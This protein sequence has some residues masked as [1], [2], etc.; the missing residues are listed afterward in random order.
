[1]TAAALGFDANDEADED[2]DEDDED[3]A[4]V[5][6]KRY[7]IGRANEDKDDEV[8]V[9]SECSE[10]GNDEDDALDDLAQNVRDATLELV[11]LLDSESLLKLTVMLEALSL[12]PADRIASLV[13]LVL[14]EVEQAIEEDSSDWRNSGALPSTRRSSSEAAPEQADCDLS[15][16]CK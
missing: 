1:M 14:S 13:S 15:Y 11:D 8:D 2:E 16:P 10:L 12:S 7:N 5:P 9:P 4:D 6:E 3:D